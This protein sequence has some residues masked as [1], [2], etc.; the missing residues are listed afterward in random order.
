MKLEPQNLELANKVLA[1]AKKKPVAVADPAAVLQNQLIKHQLDS[2]AC[3]D[4]LS[5]IMHYG[6]ECNKITVAKIGLQLNG[7]MDR[8]SDAVDKAVPQISFVFHDSNVNI[9]GIFNPQRE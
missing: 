3:L 2:D 4:V 9:N 1:A 6:K 7:L 5:T 8:D